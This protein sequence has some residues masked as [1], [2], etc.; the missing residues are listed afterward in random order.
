M[1]HVGESEVISDNVCQHE[2]DPGPKA[3]LFSVESETE[4]MCSMPR[5][6]KSCGADTEMRGHKTEPVSRQGHETNEEERPTGNYSL[7]GLQKNHSKNDRLSHDRV[8][9]Y[10]E[11]KHKAINSKNKSAAGQNGSVMHR[12]EPGGTKYNYASASKGA[13]VLAF[14]KEAK[15]A[16]NILGKDQDK[17]LRNPC[18]VEEKFV[19]IELSEETLIDTIELANFEH[20]SSNLKEFELLGSA[21]YPTDTWVKLGN[22]T[23]KN[24]KHSR[25]VHTD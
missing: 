17:Y 7:Q 21:V 13:K 1:M 24:V 15:G 3:F 22:F 20:Y 25:K 8:L 14:N 9:G 18:S 16:S 4:D 2:K 19:V 11:F 5:G 6:C 23:A 12:V 10:D